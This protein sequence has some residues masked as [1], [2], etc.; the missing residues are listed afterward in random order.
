MLVG[1]G[2]ILAR[3]A[4]DFSRILMFWHL[5]SPKI[6][7]PQ[8]LVLTL[9][10]SHRCAAAVLRQESQETSERTTR[11]I[12]EQSHMCV[13]RARKQN[14]GWV[15]SE[16]R[17]LGEQ[18]RK[19]DSGH[20]HSLCSP[21]VH[22]LVPNRAAEQT[23]RRR[24]RPRRRFRCPL[25]ESAKREPRNARRPHAVLIWHTYYTSHTHILPVLHTASVL[26]PCMLY[27]HMV[28]TSIIHAGS[29]HSLMYSSPHF[30]RTRSALSSACV[31]PMASNPLIIS[32]S[33]SR[34]GVGVG[35]RLSRFLQ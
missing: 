24:P 21:A 25:P 34:I 3:A 28:D 9:G 26:C 4:R 5:K 6:A 7:G 31:A 11:T 12:G 2:A 8:G 13:C 1:F 29:H 18:A 14:A 15:M 10:S 27:V 33:V 20:H 17:A 22:G 23:P 16:Q 19:Y 35:A 30:M 32:R